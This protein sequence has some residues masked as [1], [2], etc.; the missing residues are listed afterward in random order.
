MFFYKL[1][2]PVNSADIGNVSSQIGNII[3][4]SSPF[5]QNVDFSKKA[6]LAQ[7]PI[8]ALNPNAKHSNIYRLPSLISHVNNLTVLD[9]KARNVFEQF[10]LGNYQ[11]L[12][13]LISEKEQ[14]HSCSLLQIYPA[15]GDPLYIDYGKT[16]FVFV[17]D[18]LVD[19]NALPRIKFNDFNEYL[20]TI[21]NNYFNAQDEKNKYG[22][23][24]VKKLVLKNEKISTDIFYLNSICSGLYVSERLKSAIEINN[25]TGVRFIAVENIVEPLPILR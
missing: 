4:N 8:F 17:T 19:D 14:Y 25:L 18:I 23:Y 24:R 10:N 12:D 6:V 22:K 13:L 1:C 20:A 3:R 7:S 21:R 15:Q 9:L 11:L 5:L 16:E 2:Y